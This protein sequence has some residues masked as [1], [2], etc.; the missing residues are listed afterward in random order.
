MFISDK[1]MFN[2]VSCDEYNV[3][4]VYFENN[5]VNDMKIPFSVSVNSDSKDGIYPVYKEETNIP[6]QVILNLAYVDETDN[7]ATF[8]NEIF[9]RIKTWL[10]TD[11][12][13][14]FI[15]EDYPDYVLYLKCVKIQDKLTFGNQGFLEVTFQPYTHYFYKQFETVIL[16][17]GDNATTIEN[18][19]REVCYPIITA[20]TTDDIINTIEINDMTLKLQLNEPVS[21]DNKMLTVLNANGENRLSYCNR[22][23]IKL[24]PGSNNLKLYGYGKV[25]IKAEFPVIL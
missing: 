18:I 22:K 23:W 4:L 7:L 2:G 19:S 25:K 10:I 17:S 9:K 16:L 14:P 12:F 6:D 24:L 8:S 3:R 11:S 13:A 15:T 21:V 1:F 20:E 5:I